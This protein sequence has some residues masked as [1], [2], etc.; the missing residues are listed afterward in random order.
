MKTIV[1]RV[2]ADLERDAVIPTGGGFSM[3]FP[4]GL[5][6]GAPTVE[7]PDPPEAERTRLT[8]EEVGS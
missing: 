4:F 8:P 7:R 5:N 1:Q 6:R 3:R 2:I